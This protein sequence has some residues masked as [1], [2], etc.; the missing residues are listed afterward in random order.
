MGYTFFDTAE[1]YGTPD[2]PHDNEEL[3]G[4]IKKC[5]T[6]NTKCSTINNV[7]EEAIHFSP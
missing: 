1:V 7:Q 2:N 3:V 4:V 6:N 5:L